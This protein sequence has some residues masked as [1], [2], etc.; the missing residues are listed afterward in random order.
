M[1][2]ATRQVILLTAPNIFKEA[3]DMMQ[4]YFDF[5]ATAQPGLLPW[6]RQPLTKRA[7]GASMETDP[8]SQAFPDMAAFLSKCR[9]GAE[10]LLQEEAELAFLSQVRCGETQQI[11]NQG[12]LSGLLYGT[13]VS[14]AARMSREA[15]ITGSLMQLYEMSG[16]MEN[17]HFQNHDAFTTLLNP[18]V[19]M[20]RVFEAVSRVPISDSQRMALLRFFQEIDDWHELIRDHL[21]TLQEI[22][23]AAFP[24]V[25]NRFHQKVKELEQAGKSAEPFHWLERMGSD[26][27]TFRTEDPYHLQVSLTYFNYIGFAFTFRPNLPLKIHHGVLFEELSALRDGRKA[28]DQLTEQQL[29]AISDPTRLAIIR[30]LH[31][32]EQYVQQLADALGLTPATLS[33]HI[34]QLHQ[35]LL[36]SLRV[37][38]RRSYYSINPAE[39]TGLAKDLSRLAGEGK[40]ET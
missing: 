4:S 27:S 6:A 40:E 3:C 9:A 26:T 15:F 33:H 8:V 30:L 1:P 22:F 25:K 28:R 7:S 21:L 18:D 16:E 23:K 36:L 32:G 5:Q 31:E 37:E 11:N 20:Y 29:K 13:G 12:F 14:D 24:Q 39:L 38:G 19:E 2:K 34:S 17:D 10:K 35:A